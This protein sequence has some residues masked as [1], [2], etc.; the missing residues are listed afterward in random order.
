MDP[1]VIKVAGGLR[2]TQLTKVRV[3]APRTLGI[4]ALAAAIAAAAAIGCAV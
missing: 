4:K 2:Q 1:G 3:V